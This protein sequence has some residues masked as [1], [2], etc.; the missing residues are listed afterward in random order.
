MTF[1]LIYSVRKSPSIACTSPTRWICIS[2]GYTIT[3]QHRLKKIWSKVA[4]EWEPMENNRAPCPIASGKPPTMKMIP[5]LWEGCSSIWFYSTI[6]KLFLMSRWNHTWYNFTCCSLTFPCG[7]SWGERFYP[8]YSHTL[9]TGILWWDPLWAIFSQIK[10]L[11]SSHL[12]SEGRFYNLL[13]YLHGP[14]LDPLPSVHVFF[15]FWEQSWTQYYR[16]GLTSIM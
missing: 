8:L 9:N 11:N 14:L 6:K 3:E 7:S 15:E 5:H 10:R 16:C 12:S 4:Q 13:F 1:L 2:Y